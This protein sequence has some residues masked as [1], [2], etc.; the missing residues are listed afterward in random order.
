MPGITASAFPW[1]Q[2]FLPRRTQFS[3]PFLMIPFVLLRQGPTS[4]SWLFLCSSPPAVSDY[5]FLR[6]L[7]EKALAPPLSERMISTRFFLILPRRQFTLAHPL[8]S[9][10]GLQCAWLFCPITPF[11]PLPLTQFLFFPPSSFIGV[12]GPI[13]YG[14]FFSLLFFLHCIDVDCAPFSSFFGLDFLFP[15]GFFLSPFL[16]GI[17][18]F[19]FFSLL[20]P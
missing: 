20:F 19:S 10:F 13:N 8:V 15:N 18:A 9:P 12:F 1:Y 14:L 3:F 16:L 17:W 5:L 11:R 6:P 4:P 2:K 7:W